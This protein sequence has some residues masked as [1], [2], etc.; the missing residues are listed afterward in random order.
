MAREQ[1]ARTRRPDGRPE[2]ARDR[3]FF[4]LRESGYTGPIN[5]DGRKPDMSDPRER[6][7]VAIL[8]RMRPPLSFHASGAEGEAVPGHG[9]SDPTATAPREKGSHADD[10]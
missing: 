1:Q 5:Q 9:C 10:Y 7:A 2:T 3:R 8:A 4:D 6:E